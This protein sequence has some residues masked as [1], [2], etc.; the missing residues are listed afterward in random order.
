[1]LKVANL[2]TQVKHRLSA[3]VANMLVYIHDDNSPPLLDNNN[4][5]SYRMAAS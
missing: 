3:T 4:N 1:M 2:K 5:N